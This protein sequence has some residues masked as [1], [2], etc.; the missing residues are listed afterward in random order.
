MPSL[1][2]SLPEG[3]TISR[4]KN[5]A[6][7]VF[8]AILREG[9]LIN[10]LVQGAPTTAM[11]R[12]PEPETPDQLIDMAAQRMYALAHADARQEGRI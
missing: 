10:P 11:F 12:H 5:N 7:G 6:G 1:S 4:A 2:E 3:Y 9:E 8:V